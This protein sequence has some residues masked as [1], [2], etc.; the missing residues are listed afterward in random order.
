MDELFIEPN[1]GMACHLYYTPGANPW[2]VRLIDIDSDNTVTLRRF[3][4]VAKA[5]AFV[6]YCLPNHD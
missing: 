1:D 2:C 3:S 6:R 4:D 5:R